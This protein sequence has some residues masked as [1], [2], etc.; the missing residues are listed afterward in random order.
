[1]SLTSGNG[2]WPF[3]V[4]RFYLMMLRA[5]NISIQSLY[6]PETDWNETY[7]NY[8]NVIVFFK[9]FFAKINTNAFLKDSMYKALSKAIKISSPNPII[10]KLIDVETYEAFIE[11]NEKLQRA[12][13]VRS[14]T[15]LLSVLFTG[16]AQ[17]TSSIGRLQRAMSLNLSPVSKGVPDSIS[18]MVSVP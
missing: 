18:K 8:K 17:N 6:T 10:T 2:N 15:E 3:S 1:M 14:F 11:L 9:E 12:L 4:F 13:R 5:T 7:I 16:V